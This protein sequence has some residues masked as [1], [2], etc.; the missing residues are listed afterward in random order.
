MNQKLQ[1][2]IW[3]SVWVPAVH[4]LSENSVRLEKHSSEILQTHLQSLL[5]NVNVP[6][7]KRPH[8]TQF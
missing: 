1:E 3:K 4:V 6:F 5:L 7:P 2:G 8:Q